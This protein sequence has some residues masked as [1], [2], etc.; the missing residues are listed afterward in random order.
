MALHKKAS[1][2]KPLHKK[3]KKP[4]AKKAKR[5]RRRRKPP[6]LVKQQIVGAELIEG[7]AVVYQL[8][9]VQ[10]GKAGCKC[11]RGRPHGP[12][13]YAYWSSKGRTR[14]QYIGKELRSVQQVREAKEARL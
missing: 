3:T 9:H 5:D 8:E 4:P 6:R 14:Q 12:Y 1:R 11:T 13:W 7:A 2:R 10:C